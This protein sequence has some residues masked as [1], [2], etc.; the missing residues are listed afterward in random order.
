MKQN[1]F[2]AVV[3]VVFLL[4]LSIPVSTGAARVD[5][6]YKFDPNSLGITPFGTDSK[7]AIDGDL[8][9]NAVLNTSIPAK[10]AAMPSGLEN[11]PALYLLGTGL[12]GLV[13][14]RRRRRD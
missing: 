8:Q 13:G 14:F 9:E 3:L 6:V 7:F 11:A 5:L 12:I 4:L 2:S 1:I 10:G